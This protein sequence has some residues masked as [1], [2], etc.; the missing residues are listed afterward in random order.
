MRFSRLG[1]G[2]VLALVGS[3]A[4]AQQSSLSITTSPSL[5]TGTVGALY[6][7]ML[8]ATG[9]APPYAW[10]QVSGLL[11]NGLNLSA[12]GSISG[13]PTTLGTFTFTLQVTDSVFDTAMQTFILT[14]APVTASSLAITTTSLP[15]A[16]VN[17]LYS[18]TL[19]ATGGFLPYTWSLSSGSLPPGL[20]LS[21]SGAITGTPTLV[22]VFTFTVSVTDR[23]S[24]SAAQM[25]TITVPSAAVVTSSLP[26]F[27]AGG[28]FVTGFYVLN[29]NG[30]P[31]SFAIAFNNDMGQPAALPFAGLNTTATLADTIV[32]LGVK[33]YEA[34]TYQGALISGSGV[35]TA[36]PG[37]TIQALVRRLGSDGSYYEAAI[38]SSTG[39]FE[40]A[41]PFDA[42][43]FAPTGAQIYTGFAIANMD[44]ANPSNVTCVARDALGNFIPNAVSVPPL[45]PLGHFAGYQFPALAGLRGTLNC[46]STTE[47]GAVALRAIGTNAISSLPVILIP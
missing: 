15:Q 33:Y 37:I 2:A 17:L 1:I 34:G 27:A 38:P 18:Q 41:I 13:T 36:N 6:S 45:N 25:L 40:F 11:P 35:I 42:T 30:Q 7:Q 47:V 46:N 23:A 9:G 28:G 3:L 19:A 22:G 39:N 14:I 21:S 20:S 5:P 24:N 31:A 4:Q 29:G 10:S 32:G 12:N 16:S 8:S 26:H 43:T 44:P